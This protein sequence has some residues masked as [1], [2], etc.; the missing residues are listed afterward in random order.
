LG[1][2]LY[3]AASPVP[4][5]LFIETPSSLPLQASVKSHMKK[6]QEV[7]MVYW[8]VTSFYNMIPIMENFDLYGA[9]YELSRFTN[10]RAEVSQKDK[11]KERKYNFLVY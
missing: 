8:Y 7:F 10:R 6:L 11:K 1:N 5:N 2:Q 9:R 4:H 3:C